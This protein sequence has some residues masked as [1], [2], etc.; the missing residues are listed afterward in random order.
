MENEFRYALS[1]YEKAMPDD[2]E[3]ESKFLGARRCGFDSVEICIDSHKGRQ[4][5]LMWD[6][7]R[8]A[9]F[10]A[11]MSQ[12][13]MRVYTVSLSL[14]RSCPLG[15]L[16]K[17][18]N[19]KS[20]D[21]LRRGL[22]FTAAT[23]ARL[24]LINGYD[25]FDEPSTQKTS[26]RFEY[27]LRIA[28]QMA[29][30]CGVIIGIENAEKP[31]IDSVKKAVYWTSRIESPYVCV[32]ADIGNTYNSVNGNISAANEDLET[33][34]GKIAATHLKDS[35][36]GEWR[37]V[38]YGSGHVEFASSIQKLWALGVRIFTAELFIRPDIDWEKEAVYVGRFLREHLNRENKK[39]DESGRRRNHE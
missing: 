28:A 27:N 24:M 26:E 16:D 8:I 12:K 36:P 33:G 11:F 38:R 9:E 37:Y 2:M 1:L 14:L 34:R 7:S 35:L 17:D 31:F 15:S 19:A 29:A 22:E 23:G 6:G 25:V 5:R 13:G 4:E 32:Y 30:A 20:M 18:T 21:I 3:L 39:E 10:N